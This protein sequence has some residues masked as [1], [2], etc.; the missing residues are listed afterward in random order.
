[1]SHHPDTL[2]M[3]VRFKEEELQHA[4]QGARWEESIRRYH[5]VSEI[6]ESVDIYTFRMPLLIIKKNDLN[7][8]FTKKKM[9]NVLEKNL[10]LT[11]THLQILFVSDF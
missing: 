10:P 9:I 2:G 8:L 11:G 5:V 4:G 3:Y 6:E 7:V 1:M